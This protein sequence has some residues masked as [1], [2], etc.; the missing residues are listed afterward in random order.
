M[1]DEA[2]KICS[3][4][5]GEKP[6]SGF[7]RNASKPDGFD[8][9]C[10]CCVSKRKKSQYSKKKKSQKYRHQFESH[11][12]GTYSADENDFIKVLGLAIVEGIEDGKL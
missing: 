6:L 12:L 8:S 11:I 5:D 7:H 4:C 2:K 1:K 9:A 10:K 3:K